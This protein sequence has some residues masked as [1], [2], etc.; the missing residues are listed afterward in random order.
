MDEA[1]LLGEL[2]KV[3]GD[4]LE[5]RRGLIAFSKMDAIEMDRRA[6]TLEREALDRMKALLPAMPAAAVLHQLRTRLQR[7]DDHLGELASKEG[8]AETSRM[9]ESDDIV[10]RAFEDVLELLDEG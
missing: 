10:W 1:K 3:A 9:L 7:M 4:A 6:R 5:T 8:I 2:R